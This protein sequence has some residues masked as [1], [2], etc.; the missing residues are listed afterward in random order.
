MFL[1][2][3][4]RHL[5]RKIAMPAKNH[6][7]LLPIMT[8]AILAAPAAALSAAPDFQQQAGIA[9]VVLW[10]AGLGWGFHTMLHHRLAAEDRL[11]R[12][13][14]EVVFERDARAAQLRCTR[15]CMLTLDTEWQRL[16][17]CLRNGRLD[18]VADG[19]RAVEG[20]ILQLHETA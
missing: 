16:D 5:F 8:L 3:N 7:A 2:E 13:E 15:L 11:A 4:N 17:E 18:H 20:A 10:L 19:M 12:L 1:M 6:R 9:A 14:A